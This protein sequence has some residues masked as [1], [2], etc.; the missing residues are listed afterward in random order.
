AL[1][2]GTLR[3][4]WLGAPACRA[5]ATR[6]ERPIARVPRL[7]AQRQPGNERPHARAPRLAAQR[8]PGTERPCARVPRLAAQRQPGDRTTTRAGAPACR[9]AATRDE[10][11]STSSTRRSP[12]SYR[13]RTDP[14]KA[15]KQPPPKVAQRP[16]PKAAQPPPT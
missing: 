16:P 9:E 13:S 7:A 3:I 6:D 11:Q 12:V 1:A 15:A 2:G 5:A 14:A 8:Q 4:P 10:L